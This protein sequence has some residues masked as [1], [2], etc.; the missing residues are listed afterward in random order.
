MRRIKLTVLA[1]LLAICWVGLQPAANTL[2]GISMIRQGD[3]IAVTITTSAECDYNAFVTDSKPERI[4]VDLSDVI[5]DLPQKL[6]YKLPIKSIKSI[7]TSQYTSEPSPQARVVFDINRPIEFVS[8]Q[9]G[10]SVVIKL[11]AVPEELASVYWVSTGSTDMAAV[12]PAVEEPAAEE[13]KAEEP[14][15]AVE[16]S[17][18]ATEETGVQGE[19]SDTAAEETGVQVV[20]SEEKTV[21]KPVAQTPPTPVEK[22]EVVPEAPASSTQSSVETSESAA[23]PQSDEIAP[24]PIS[25]GPAMETA[26]KRKRVEYSA[27]REKDPFISLVGMATGKVSKGLPSLENLKLVGILE[28]N[29]TSSALLEDGEGN[30]YILKPNDRIQ[31]GYLVSVSNNKATFQITEYGWTRTVALELQIPEI[32]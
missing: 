5:N 10:N 4:V 1:L 20:E 30:G 29:R 28:D 3:S 12:E 13:N 8:S 14:K 18:T 16:E 11:A 2:E 21:E 27:D 25:P 24:L 26:P 23:A 6:F 7:R 32:K 15:A 31:S 22:S 19:E 9:A 17:D